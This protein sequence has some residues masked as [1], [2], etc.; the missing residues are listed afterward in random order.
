MHCKQTPSPGYNSLR[1]CSQ[2]LSNLPDAD[3]LVVGAG[4]HLFSSL[5]K[6]GQADLDAVDDVVSDVLWLRDQHPNMIWVSGQR[7][8]LAVTAEEPDDYQLESWAQVYHLSCLM[9]RRAINAPTN[10]ICP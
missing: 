10:V 7:P 3:A 4:V 5:S 9:V 6:D 1:T 8:A 2:C